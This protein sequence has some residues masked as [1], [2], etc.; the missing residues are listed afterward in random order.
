MTATAR[1]LIFVLT[2]DG[3]F[4]DV[5][6]RAAEAFGH[7]FQCRDD[8]GRH[9]ASAR[10]TACEVEVIDKEDR[11]ADFLCDDHYTLRVA[12]RGDDHFT[13]AFEAHVKALL[14]HAQ[15][16]WQRSVWAPDRHPPVR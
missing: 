14:E 12:I 1:W 6:R 9:V 11:L 4:E 8:E 2:S 5:V 3:S 16:R 13:L 7:P 15:L 10:L